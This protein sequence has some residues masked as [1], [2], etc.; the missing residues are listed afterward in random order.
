M[1][2]RSRKR[3]KRKQLRELHDSEQQRLNAWFSHKGPAVR[4]HPNGPPPE[5]LPSAPVMCMEDAFESFH[6]S[7]L[8][9]S[10]EDVGC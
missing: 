10:Q 2:K 1:S 3:Q 5:P 7:R 6:L 9:P 8:N 4:V